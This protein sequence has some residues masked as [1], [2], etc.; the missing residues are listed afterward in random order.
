VKPAFV[1][2]SSVALAWCFVDEA[3]PATRDLLSRM[4]TETAIVPGWWFLELTNALVMAERKRRISP[5]D[6]AEYMAL[7]ESLRL[8]IDGAGAERAFTH[9]LHLCRTY[10]LTSYDAVYLDL[11][12]RR[13][14]PLATLDQ[15]LRR[16]AKKVGVKLLG[17]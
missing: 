1:I 14:L 11:A 17:L 10:Q 9:V 8:E 16:A 4:D 5:A 6:L 13:N 7:V 12:I 2:D 15:P 3:T